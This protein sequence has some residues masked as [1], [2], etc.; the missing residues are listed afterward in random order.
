MEKKKKDYD[1]TAVKYDPCGKLNQNQM[2]SD[3]KRN[4]RCF[5]F[6]LKR[7]YF[8]LSSSREV[9]ETVKKEI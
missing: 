7:T 2:K 1:L 6:A 8:F 5:I 4:N 9:E 3:E